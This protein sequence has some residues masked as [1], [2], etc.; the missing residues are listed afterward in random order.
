MVQLSYYERNV[1]ADREGF[2]SLSNLI[3]TLNADERHKGWRWFP[4]VEAYIGV[5]FN[6]EEK[7]RIREATQVTKEIFNDAIVSKHN[8]LYTLR[9]LGL[10]PKIPKTLFDQE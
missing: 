2:G 1:I 9:N 8:I 4:T 7:D 10:L 6:L 3:E 5:R